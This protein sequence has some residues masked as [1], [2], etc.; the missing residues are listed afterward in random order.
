[1]R[2]VNLGSLESRPLFH[3]YLANNLTEYAFMRVRNLTAKGFKSFKI[4]KTDSETK[5]FLIE[6]RKECTD[7]EELVTET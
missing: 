7:H 3:T 1:M 5:T 4:T 6:R 2:K